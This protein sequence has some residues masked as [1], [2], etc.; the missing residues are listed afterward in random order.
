MSHDREERAGVAGAASGRPAAAG[1]SSP[2]GSSKS[3]VPGEWAESVTVLYIPRS[4]RYTPGRR[5]PR[6]R[7]VGLRSSVPK[8]ARSM[9][10]SRRQ[11]LKTTAIGAGA[12]SG[13]LGFPMVSPAQ[14]KK[15]TVWW[16]RGY[17]KEEDEAM[18]KIA[19]EFKKA[20]NV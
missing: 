17:Y 7:G 15:L 6:R 9:R 20:K 16:N 5:E 4:A 1:P 8:E 3:R 12:V 10:Q 2:A 11:F 19:D 13:A 14:P 18:L